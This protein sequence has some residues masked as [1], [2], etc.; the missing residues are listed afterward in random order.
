MSFYSDHNGAFIQGM[1]DAGE[2]KGFI[3]QRFG[4]HE[5]QSAYA[6]MFEETKNLAREE[7]IPPL[8]A[9]WKVLDRIYREKTPPPACEKGC[10]HC[11]YTGVSIT[12]LEWD[13]I[14]NHVKEKEI[15]LNKIIERSQ[16]SVDRVAKV[17]ESGVD[18]ET[19]DWYRTVVNQPCP[20]LDEDQTCS[21]HEDRP[22]DCR[23][24]LAFRGVCE[25]KNLEHAQ[26]GATVEEAAAPTIIAR[27]Q[28]EQTPKIRRR[29]FDGTQKLR[30]MQHWLL[31]WKKKSSRKKR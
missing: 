28:Y 26:R 2:L 21:I 4:E 9:F 12:Q 16:K 20:F 5:I 11:C 18:P 22:L 3:Q 13:D 14:L 15:D 25:S 29:K 30:L 1:T 27:L 17:L 10:A 19:V 31:L 23:L 6:S 24:M 8:R 7:K